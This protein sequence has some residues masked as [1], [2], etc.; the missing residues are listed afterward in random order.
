M[1]KYFFL[2][3]YYLSK[4]YLCKNPGIKEA[5]K[6]FESSKEKTYKSFEEFLQD[7]PIYFVKD[8]FINRTIR[9]I[10]KSAGVKYQ[11]YVFIDKASP[12][13]KTAFLR[14][15]ENGKLINGKGTYFTPWKSEKNIIYF[16]IID[17]RPLVDMTDEMDWQNGDM[18]AEVITAVTNANNMAAMRGDGKTAQ[19]IFYVLI[20]CVIAVLL[21]GVMIYTS[22]QNTKHT[23][24]LLNKIV[25][26]TK[27]S[28]T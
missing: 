27:P 10:Y 12:T 9:N 2:L 6:E 21:L 3:K 17:G 22:D 8:T 26:Q 5:K 14:K 1:N 23:L 28:T 13:D 7:C 4:I 16:D 25:E 19:Y 18:C 15:P 11:Q 20:L 24:E